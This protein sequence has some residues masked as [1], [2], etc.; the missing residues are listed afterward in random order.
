MKT[1]KKALSI[2]LLVMMILTAWVFVAPE[3]AEAKRGA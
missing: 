3:K 2:V 1:M